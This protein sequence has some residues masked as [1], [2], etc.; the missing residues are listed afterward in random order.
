RPRLVS[1]DARRLAGRVDEPGAVG[2][3]DRVPRGGD[4][5][6][7][8]SARRR[9]GRREEGL[10]I[11]LAHCRA[12]DTSDPLRAVR[13]RF[14]RAAEDTVYLDGN[15]IGAMPA[16]AAERVQRVMQDG[17]RD[18]RRRG[19][20]RSDWLEKPGRMGE[21]VAPTLGA[22]RG[23][24]VFSTNTTIT[25]YKPLGYAWQPD[26]SRPVIV[27]EPTTSRPTCM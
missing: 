19:W 15:S 21:G 18:A 23:D 3:P 4:P 12:L 2:A 26:R 11:D 5:I 13:E 22:G 8:G 7:A 16:D 6:G 25:P 24:L 27:T 20:N 1:G 10:M 9:A 14:A 17:W